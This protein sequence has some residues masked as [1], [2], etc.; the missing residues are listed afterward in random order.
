MLLEETVM[1]K[2]F[3]LK[4][5][6]I[7]T[8]PVLLSACVSLMDKAGQLIDGSAFAQKTTHFTAPMAQASNFP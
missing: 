4:L 6:L 3:K 8:A 7:L 5:M 2:F 1:K